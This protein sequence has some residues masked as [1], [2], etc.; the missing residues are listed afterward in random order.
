MI[1]TFLLANWR[2]VALAVVIGGL[3]A[4]AGF[5]HHRATA[6]QA[7]FDVFVAQ[8]K[9]K[10]IAAESA[11]RAKEAADKLKKE[12]ADA[13]NKAAV[14]D[15]NAT[16]ERLRAEHSRSDLVPAAPAGSSNPSL[17]CFDRP[18]LIGALRRFEEG[19]EGIAAEGDRAI[20]D[21]DTAKRWAQP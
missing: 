4:Y 1:L 2:M 7:D 10:G 9:A 19:I 8:T 13:Q 11:A 16:L 3:S 6:I 20:A 14:A 15:L 21:L 18:E 17:A 5:W 12:T